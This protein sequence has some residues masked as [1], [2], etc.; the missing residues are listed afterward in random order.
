MKKILIFG[1]GNWIEI[2]KDSISRTGISHE[3]LVTSDPRGFHRNKSRF[4]I[5]ILGD[6]KNDFLYKACLRM[7]EG[8][9]EAECSKTVIC[10]TDNRFII[11]AEEKGAEKL[12]DFRTQDSLRLN[13]YIQFVLGI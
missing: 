9:G 2:I 5:L 4:D 1:M 3:V 7:L 12:M 13:G 6:S 8:L 10:S 11:E